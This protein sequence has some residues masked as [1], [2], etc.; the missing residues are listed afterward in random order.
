MYLAIC[1]RPDISYAVS[2]L[3]Y[4][5]TCFNSTHW[6]AAKRVLGYLKGT[7]DLGLIYTKTSQSVEGY[8]N[9]DWANCPLDRK[10][11]TE[12]AFI[13]SGSSVSWE[14]RKQRTVALF[15]TKSEYMSL[16]ETAKQATYLRRFLDELGFPKIADIK[17][18]CDNN[19]AQKLVENPVFHNQTK[20]IDV[21]HHYVREA[22]N[23]GILKVEHIPTTEMA[24]DFLTKA[25]PAPKLRKCLNLLGL[26]K[27]EFSA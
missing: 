23:R 5:N 10:S 7:S 2:Y 22:I 6:T 24:S 26:M 19:G 8:V 20:H 4:F 21:R 11:Y 25:V 13:L 15:S 18:F 1:T 14:S 17:I 3:S 27:E 16:T 12:Y 9:A